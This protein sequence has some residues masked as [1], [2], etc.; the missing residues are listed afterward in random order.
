MGGFCRPLEALHQQLKGFVQDPKDRSKA[1]GDVGG[2]RPLE[3]PENLA[4]EPVIIMF[5]KHQRAILK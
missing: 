1:L 3:A 2:R 5:A 4:G